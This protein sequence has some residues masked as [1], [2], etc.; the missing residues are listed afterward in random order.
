MNRSP[1][2]LAHVQ[3]LRA[4][5]C[6]MVVFHHALNFAWPPGGI[7]P[8]WNLGAHG[9]EVFFVISGFIIAWTLHGRPLDPVDFLRRRLLRIVPLYWLALLLVARR[10]LWDPSRQADLLRDLFFIP[11]FSPGYPGQIYPA[12][13]PGWS[14]NY[15]VFFYLALAASMVLVRRPFVLVAAMLAALVLVGG[16]AGP[17]D[18]A[19]AIFYTRPYLLLFAAGMGVA[20]AVRHGLRIDSH[21]TLWTLAAACLVAIVSPAPGPS[22]VTLGVPATLLVWA[23]V[24]LSTG[25]RP[26]R[27]L[28]LLGTIGTASYSIYLF[29]G[30]GQSAAVSF[31]RRVLE[32]PLPATDAMRLVE[33]AVTVS[34]GVLAGW[35]AYQ[36]LERPL[37]RWVRRW[38]ERDVPRAPV[39]SRPARL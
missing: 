23:A 7:P 26:G 3:Y 20:A 17:F 11:H 13:V 15:E 9:V 33:L 36:V 34:A 16:V 24:C 6:T 21:A 39:N 28:P 19:T 10:D 25:E 27:A 8:S 12:L 29:H 38:S 37:S 35:L 1:S 5:A 4:I 31:M 32:W 22:L 14:L 2:A 30:W 18:D